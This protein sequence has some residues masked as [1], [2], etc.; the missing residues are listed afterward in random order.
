M[1]AVAGFFRKRLG[2]RAFGKALGVVRGQ[3]WGKTRAYCD[4]GATG[5]WINLKD[6]QVGGIVEAGR[7]YGALRAELTE[8]MLAITEPKSGSPVFSR[9]RPPEEVYQGE[10]LRWAPDLIVERVGRR[11][12]P[13][14]KNIDNQYLNRLSSDESISI[15]S[16]DSGLRLTRMPTWRH[17]FPCV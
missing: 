6:R 3:D 2:R 5:V 7:E 1:P 12:R 9:V 13:Y 11:N 15:P 4:H 14:E 17:H 10:Q 16:L 8:R